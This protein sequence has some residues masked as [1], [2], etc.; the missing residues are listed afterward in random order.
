[1]KI[2]VIP[3]DSPVV[4]IMLVIISECFPAET[5][6]DAQLKLAVHIQS[7]TRTASASTSLDQPR[8]A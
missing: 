5:C 8:P 4:H 7:C 2:F 3:F 6:R 1:M